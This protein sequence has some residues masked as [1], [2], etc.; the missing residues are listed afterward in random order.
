MSDS[1]RYP[2]VADAARAAIDVQDACNT[3]GV[4]L[5]MFEAA[6][7]LRNAAGIPDLGPEWTGGVNRH[8]VMQLFAYK[9]AA[10]CIAEPMDQTNQDIYTEALRQCDRLIQEASCGA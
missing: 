8:P 7:T 9:L 1:L 2:T 4:A 6:R 5:S 10:L 3:S